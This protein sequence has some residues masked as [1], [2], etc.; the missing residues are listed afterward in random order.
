MIIRIYIDKNP[1]MIYGC[2]KYM[3]SFERCYCGGA[4]DYNLSDK[5]FKKKIK[6]VRLN[7]K[8]KLDSDKNITKYY[9]KNKKIY[10]NNENLKIDDIFFETELDFHNIVINQYIHKNLGLFY[11]YNLRKKQIMIIFHHGL[12]DFAKAFIYINLIE[13]VTTNMIEKIPEYKYYPILSELLIF[14]SI[15]KLINFKKNL[16]VDKNLYGLNI[17]HTSSM[18]NNLVKYVKEN[19]GN[20]KT[21]VILFAIVLKKIFNSSNKELKKINVGIL[22]GL[23]NDRFRNNYTIIPIIVKNDSFVNILKNLKSE[24]RKNYYHSLSIYNMLNYIYPKSYNENFD[25]LITNCYS[26]KKFNY[27]NFIRFMIDDSTPALYIS[28]CSDINRSSISYLRNTNDVNVEK[29]EKNITL[30]DII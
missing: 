2:D 13:P 25:V 17:S 3:L 12:Y 18:N 20:Y 24:I 22:V 15:I 7:I 30:K 11:V 5:D 16:I 8:N 21:K 14:Y 23:K 6:E 10:M 28:I 29:L 1:N 26:K 9:N 19:I 4:V 27:L